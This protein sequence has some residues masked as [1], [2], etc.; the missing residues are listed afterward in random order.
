MCHPFYMSRLEY[1]KKYNYNWRTRLMMEFEKHRTYW[2]T[3]TFDDEHLPHEYYDP[4]QKRIISVREQATDIIQRFWKRLRSKCDYHSFGLHFKYYAVS[5]NGEEFNRFHIHALVFADGTS[6]VLQEK[7]AKPLFRLIDETWKLGRTQIRVAD[8]KKIRYITKYIFKRCFDDSYHSWKSNGIG[9]SYMSQYLTDYLRIHLQDFIH[10]GGKVRYLPS[11]IRHKI[12]DDDMLYQV[13][14]R[15]MSH[16]PSK[17]EGYDLGFVY[18]DN[19]MKPVPLPNWIGKRIDKMMY[20][21]NKLFHLI[22]YGGRI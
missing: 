20:D 8:A 5:E 7:T 9:M 14:E 13:N 10:L 17:D 11:Y 3:L 19:W 12:F 1:L 2:L 21:N 22:K 6:P 4:K 15:Y 18:Y 16:L